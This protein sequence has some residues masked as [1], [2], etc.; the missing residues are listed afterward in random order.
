MTRRFKI[1]NLAG[2]CLLTLLLS[3]NSSSSASINLSID[4][5]ALPLTIFSSLVGSASTHCF[6]I[7]LSADCSS[8]LS[9]IIFSSLV[10][11]ASRHCFFAGFPSSSTSWLPWLSSSL[12][13]SLLISSICF[14]EQTPSPLCDR[15]SLFAVPLPSDTELSSS[16]LSFWSSS[17]SSS[18][19]EYVNVIF[20]FD[21]LFGTTECFMSET[22]PRTSSS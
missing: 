8:A 4:S 21:G 22:F 18:E 16:S 12:L 10:R 9:L 6:S 2:C 14:S 20:L 19:S 11:S 15:P 7:N 5:S 17:S 13:P 1:L 3:F